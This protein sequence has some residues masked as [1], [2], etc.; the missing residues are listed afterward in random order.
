MTMAICL[1]TSA[2]KVIITK[3]VT[4]YDRK[5]GKSIKVVGRG[6]TV[7]DAGLGD[8]Q[9]DQVHLQSW[10]IYKPDDVRV[11]L[12]LPFALFPLSVHHRSVDVCRRESIWF[13][14]E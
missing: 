6:L 5:Y 8:V 10:A 13:I 1:M 7:V 2:N 4:T 14:Q 3:N 11:F 9:S 12:I